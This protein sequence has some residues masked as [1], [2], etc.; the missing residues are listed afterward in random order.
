MFL[1]G[2]FALRCIDRMVP[3]RS[4]APRALATLEPFWLCWLGLF[5][6]CKRLLAMSMKAKFLVI[7]SGVLLLMSVVANARPTIEELKE[8]GRAHV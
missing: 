7:A 1:R 3:R 8:I 5:A 4:R 2:N 6:V